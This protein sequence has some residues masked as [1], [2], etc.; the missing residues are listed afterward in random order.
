MLKKKDKTNYGIKESNETEQRKK[1]RTPPI[2]FTADSHYF[3]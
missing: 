1:E 3:L 2:L